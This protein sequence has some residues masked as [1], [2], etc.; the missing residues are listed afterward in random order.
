MSGMLRIPVI[1]T[2]L[3]LTCWVASAQ[4][5]SNTAFNTQELGLP[6]IQ[7]YSYQ[8]Y[9]AGPSNWQIIQ[10]QEGLIYIGNKEGILEFDGVAWRLIQLPNRGVVLSLAISPDNRIYA[11]GYNE[12]GY[13]E[14]DSLGQLSYVSLK[15]YL[16]PEVRNFGEVWGVH[17][18][19]NSIYFQT[20]NYLMDWSNDKFDIIQSDSEFHNSING[21]KGLIL[22]D[23]RGPLLL[24]NQ[25]LISY[26]LNQ[27]VPQD[28]IRFILPSKI[29]ESI[30]GTAKDGL[31][32]LE[33]DSLKPI[34]TSADTYFQE[35]FIYRGIHLSNGW[36]AIATLRGGVVIIDEKGAPI[37]YLD[38]SRGIIND[39]VHHLFEDNQGGLWISTALGVS[40][41]EVISPYTVFDDRL[42]V[43]GFVNM[44]HR[45]EG[46]LYATS[47]GIVRLDKSNNWA[48]EHAFNRI[49][50]EP[51]VAFYFTSIDSDLFVATSKGVFQM[52]N[53]KILDRFD[54][55]ATAL[56]HSSIDPNRLY[57][58]LADGL[59]S[60]KF[61]G[62]KWLDDGRINGIDDDIRMIVET[63]QGDLWLESQIDGVWQV[64]FSNANSDSSFYYP[65]TKHFKAN[66]ELPAG[67]LFLGEILDNPYFTIDNQLYY[68]EKQ[69]DSILPDQSIG[70]MLGLT[71]KISLKLQDEWGNIWMWAQP[72]GSEDRH[73]HL[74]LLGTDGNYQVERIMDD[75]ITQKVGKAL[76]VED[77]GLVWYGG[78]GAIIRHDLNFDHDLPDYKTLI[79]NIIVNTDSLVYGGAT[80]WLSPLE[81]P[82]KDNALRFE[83][84]APSFDEPSANEYQ[85][86][87]EGFDKNWSDWTKETRKDYTNIPEGNYQFRVR[88]K[89]IYEQISLE[90]SYPIKILPPMHRTWWAY[91]LYT[92]LFLAMVVGI[93]KWRSQQLERD[94]LVLQKLVNDRTQEVRE[95]AE[96]LKELDKTKSR[97]FANISHEFRT[98]LTLILGPMEEISKGHF[99]GNPQRVYDLVIRNGRRL[100]N[101]VNQ[102]LDLSKIESG[103]MR[104]QVV[105]ADI[106]SF[107]KT[108][109]ASYQSLALHKGI[110]FNLETT[111]H[112][113]DLYFD[114]DKLEK[115][116]HNLLSNAFKFTPEDGTVTIILQQSSDSFIEIAVK[117]NGGGIAPDQIAYIFDRFYQADGASAN[118][119][120][121]TGIGLALT[122][123]LVELHGGLLTVTSEE[124]VGSEFKVALPLG[125]DH[126]TPDQI[127]QTPI[128][129]SR[130]SMPEQKQ[131]IDSVDNQVSIPEPP[132]P[133]VLLVE[134][135]A[136][137]RNF[138]GKTLEPYY[139]VKQ[140]HD[141]LAGWQQAIEAIPDLVLSDVMMPEMDGV[142]LCS[143]LKSDERTSH[144]PVIL[145]TAKADKQSK[146]EGLE[147]GADDYLAKPFDRDELLMLIQNRIQQRQTLRAR[148]SK[149]ITLQPKDIAITSADEKFLSKAMDLVEAHMDNSEFKV[150][151]FIEKMNL[152]RNQVE[153]KLKA[154]TDQ[155]PVEFIRVLRLKRAAQKIIKQEDTISQIAYSVGFNNLSYFAKCFKQQFGTLPSEYRGHTIDS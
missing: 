155:T 68:Y 31:F 145:L 12:L 104:L 101:L 5:N 25:R 89:N 118:A 109:V 112:S 59:A 8:D 62:N 50:S 123:E 99:Q 87:L 61:D 16:D 11:G 39:Q 108:T 152:G 76:F 96:K 110:Q 106:V 81:L 125:Q 105:K 115:V 77:N 28:N 32:L 6:Y 58:G 135:N 134:D 46:Q 80:Q 43:D 21:P 97:F 133:L 64:E 9:G 102:L 71:G 114:P 74:A 103:K 143:R 20:A 136:D 15:Q 120:Q 14:P 53:D 146:L 128:E 82:Y 56:L 3:F 69:L 147:T 36:Y 92:L 40:R 148:F 79:R 124:G 117:D 75:R 24:K 70:H 137:L 140:A 22:V 150:S 121:G 66:Q 93:V 131:K 73:R 139:A 47:R 141:G 41:A 10:N 63:P 26:F 153:R 52:R 4:R 29:G 60:L 122:K 57:V 23:E 116:I 37:Q 138:I 151:T 17:V 45:H 2:L 67:L 84:A 65:R 49:S 42:G 119:D 38:K 83:F 154:L 91:T 35:N 113:S 127:V 13:L 129:L 149:E 144:V 85:Y 27:V 95:Q 30:V 126:L 90:G 142:E 1:L 111:L 44:I 72:G 88:A 100:L 34:P 55:E 78:R 132:K 54:Y 130:E 98:P 19:E 7:N 18:V 33:N 94:K 86:F 51:M 107:I 48:R